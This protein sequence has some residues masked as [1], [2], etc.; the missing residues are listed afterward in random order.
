MLF[1]GLIGLISFGIAACGQAPHFTPAKCTEEMDFAYNAVDKMLKKFDQ[2]VE[3]IETTCT[4]P[5]HDWMDKIG[6]GYTL[7]HMVSAV[8]KIMKLDDEGNLVFASTEHP[9]FV[10]KEILIR[11]TTADLVIRE[12]KFKYA[13]LPLDMKKSRIDGRVRAFGRPDLW[14]RNISNIQTMVNQCAEKS[15]SPVSA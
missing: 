9:A 12:Y 4:K 14:T 5:H 3:G 11:L 8:E 6:C 2:Y 13:T 7:N 10:L 15:G 1:N